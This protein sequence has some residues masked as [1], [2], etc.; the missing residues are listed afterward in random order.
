MYSKRKKWKEHF[1]KTGRKWVQMGEVGERNNYFL[2]IPG[3]LK[4]GRKN[5]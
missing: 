1:M 5:V 2:Y 4:L 3:S